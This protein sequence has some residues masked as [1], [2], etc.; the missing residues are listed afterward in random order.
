VFRIELIEI[1]DGMPAE[2]LTLINEKLDAA[3]NNSNAELGKL[4][5]RL[6]SS[7][8]KAAAAAA[9]RTVVLPSADNR[10]NGNLVELNVVSFKVTATSLIIWCISRIL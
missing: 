9:A 6:Q 5:D 10:N 3:G 4:K 2:N 1:M 7:D 8:E